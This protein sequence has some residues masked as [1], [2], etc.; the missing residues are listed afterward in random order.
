[1]DLFDL[2]LVFTAIIF[3]LSI[4]C[5]YIAQK[6]GRDNLVQMFGM[7]TLLTGVPLALVF[8]HYV[9]SGEPQWKLV[10]FGFIFLYLLT[11]LLLD[12][13]FKIEFRKMPIPHTLYIIL[14]Y[15]A[16]IGFIRM[17]FAVDKTWGYVVSVSFWILLGALIYNLAG[18]RKGK[19]Q[20]P[21]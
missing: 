11:E 14:F 13:V 12:F 8:G 16:I 3:H 10:S 9:V 1:M 21:I 18:Q 2:I 5:V 7:I 17:S 20:R 6:K 15:I 4:V 19:P